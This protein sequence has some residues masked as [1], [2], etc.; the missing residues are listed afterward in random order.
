MLGPAACKELEA[1]HLILTSDDHHL[2]IA[3]LAPTS[4]SSAFLSQQLVCAS[5][6]MVIVAS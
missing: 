1:Q 2:I 3:N 4:T 5:K 6:S